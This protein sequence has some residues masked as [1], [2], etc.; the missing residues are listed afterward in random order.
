MGKF[1]FPIDFVMIDIKE[2]KQVPLLL[3][4]SFLATGVA[5]IDVRKG[6]LT[7]RVGNEEVH[8]NL[9]QSLGR[10]DFEKA[11]CKNVEKVVPISYELIDDCNNQDSMNENMMN[12]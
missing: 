3:G 6:E 2:Y 5:L 7:L 12:L 10:P 9:D 1:I 11:E 8:F 4:R